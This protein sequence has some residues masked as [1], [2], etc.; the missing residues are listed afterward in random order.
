MI[1]R[2]IISIL[3]IGGLVLSGTA[4][5][6]GTDQL[7]Q[8]GYPSA[9]HKI[10]RLVHNPN[11]VALSANDIVIWD[12]DADNGV[13][14][15]TTLVSGNSAVAGITVEIIPAQATAANTAALDIGRAN[16]GL[17]QT[18]GY[19]TVDV[20]ATHTTVHPGEAFGTS[21]NAGEITVFT[22][23]GSVPNAPTALGKAG[24]SYDALTADGTDAEV[25]LQLD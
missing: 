14:V 13:S 21:V 20:A 3:L 19:T 1:K 4:F 23:G 18:Y 24:F 17:M 7:G 10:Y 2:I 25:F 11:A 16:W 22:I 5:A 8:G 9:P 15:T 6:G 12:L